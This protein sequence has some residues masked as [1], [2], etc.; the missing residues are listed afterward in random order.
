MG[1]MNYK[2]VVIKKIR[3]S[4]ASRE[5]SQ[6]SESDIWAK[7]GLCKT[8]LMRSNFRSLISSRHHNIRELF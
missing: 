4:D 7:K 2:S 5:S 6:F 8:T 3:K 1:N